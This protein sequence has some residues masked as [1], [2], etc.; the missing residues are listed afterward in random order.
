MSLKD[1]LVHVDHTRSCKERISA[2][3][4]LAE[5]HDA[6]LTALYVVSKP[7]IPTYIIAQLGQDVLKAQ[8]EAAH[9]AS[10]EIQEMFE[11]MSAKH[12]V[13]TEWRSVDGDMV[14]QILLHARYCDLTVLGQND[15]TEDFEAPGA[16]ELPDAILLRSGRPV[17]VIPYVG[18]FNSLGENVMVA[19][20]GSRLAT[21]AVNDAIPVMKGAK[22]V[23][24]LAVNAQ[25]G[26]GI[27]KHGEIPSADMALHLARHDIK[28]QAE[29]LASG[30]LS[31]GDTLLSYAS[32]SSIDLIVMGGYGHK[33]WREVVLGGVTRHMLLHMTVPVFMTH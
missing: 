7:V 33:R 25:D 2:A 13:R 16:N 31:A 18:S 5:L 24:V 21:R 14:E 11:T 26:H 4:K 12:S 32:D 19:W 3:L 8:N 27:S 1:I 6:H 9:K 22:T 30:D 20:D 15:P 23:H 29:H 10:Q 17:I 28:A